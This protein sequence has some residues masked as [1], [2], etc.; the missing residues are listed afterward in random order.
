MTKADVLTEYDPLNI[1]TVRY[2][3]PGYKIRWCRKKDLETKRFQGWEPVRR[4]KED[5]DRLEEY[6]VQKGSTIERQDL[7]LCEMPADKCAKLVAAKKAKADRQMEA[8]RRTGL[9]R[10]GTED[11]DRT[12]DTS[13]ETLDEL[14]V[15]TQKEVISTKEEKRSRSG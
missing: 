12:G 8:I 5:L 1:L 4:K 14:G 2:T 15:G 10:F 13:L 6:G 9:K 11:R 3:R 7:I